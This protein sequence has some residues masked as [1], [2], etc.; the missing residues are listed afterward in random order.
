MRLLICLS[1]FH[2][3]RDTGLTFFVFKPAI[4][5]RSDDGGLWACAFSSFSNFELRTLSY[6]FMH[7][8]ILRVSYIDLNNHN[9]VSYT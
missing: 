1:Y 6:Y 5:V 4:G 3:I 8:M 2:A 9:I 7:L